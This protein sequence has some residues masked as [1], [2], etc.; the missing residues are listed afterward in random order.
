ML[1]SESQSFKADI[2][3]L[4][5]SFTSAGIAAASMLTLSSPSLAAEVTK[6]TKKPKVL[7]TDL[8]IKYI[9]LKQGEGPYPNPGDF[10]VVGY[11]GFLSNGTI[12]D[13]TDA[14]G[15]KPISFRFGKKQQIEGL[16][17]VLS[18]MQPGGE[19]TCSIPS[20]YAFGEKGICIENEG[21]L[22]PP[23]E[24]VKY[25]VKLIKV[26]PSYS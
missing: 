12:F 21:C 18:N 13:T 6:K 19:C 20:K 16:E 26:A 14:P 22:V 17:S 8:G 3:Q 1:Q 15:R 4:S 24:N 5:K 9:V 2:V 23:N 25:A 11:T 10:V 7:E